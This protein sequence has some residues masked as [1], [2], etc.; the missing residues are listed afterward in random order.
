MFRQSIFQKPFQGQAIILLEI[1]SVTPL[2][3]DWLS[4]PTFDESELIW[5]FEGL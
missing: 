2:V 4:F 1:Q 3:Q 5:F